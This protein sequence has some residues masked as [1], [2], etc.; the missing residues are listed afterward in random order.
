MSLYIHIP[1]CVSKCI[2]CSFVSEVAGPNRKD[3]YIEA[4]KEEIKL[5]GKEF[6]PKYEIKTV[7]IGGGT[8]SC[9]D[10]GKIKEILHTVYSCFTVQNN[11][12]ITI[13]VNPNSLTAEKVNEYVTAGVNRFSIGLQCSQPKL[14]KTLGRAH[15]FQQFE[16]SIKLLH[17]AG[18][19]NISS[20]IIIGLPKQ[21]K[22]DVKDTLYKLI[23]LN[24]PHISCYMLSVEDGT[25]LQE[26]VE[27]RLLVLPE[28]KDV[29][30]MYKTVNDVL[31]ANDFTRY[32]VS[33]FSRPGFRSRHNLVYWQRKPYLGLGVSA[34]SYVNGIRMSDTEDITE[35]CDFLSKKKIPLQSYEELTEQDKKEEFVMLSLRLKE[36]IDCDEYERTFKE[37]L[38]TTKNDTIKDLVKNGFLVLDPDNH[39]RA[40]DS[41]FLVLNRIILLLVN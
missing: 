27:S 25:K 36:G 30:A 17:E 13:E 6:N 21:T 11:A 3:N 14:L 26:L 28:E 29:L 32:E 5:R 31:K 10:A 2:Y 23:E 7:Y 34:H 16:E 33:N 40:T 19:N 4:L 15:T 39:L 22:E 9:L 35:Y 18:I 24:I 12:E 38:L 20:D 41:G 1:F 8:P 37:S